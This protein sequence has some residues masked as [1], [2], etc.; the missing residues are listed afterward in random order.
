M[1]IFLQRKSHIVMGFPINTG[2]QTE[3]AATRGV[4]SRFILNGCQKSLSEV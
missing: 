4:F 2:K 1:Y 3:P